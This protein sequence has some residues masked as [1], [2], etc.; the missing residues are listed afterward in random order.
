MTSTVGCNSTTDPYL[1]SHGNGY[2]PF[3]ND[4]KFLPGTRKEENNK[5]TRSTSVAPDLA[6]SLLDALLD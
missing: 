5:S 4:F 3:V 6:D 1:T 2:A